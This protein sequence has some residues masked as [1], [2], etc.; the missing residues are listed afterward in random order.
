MLEV[1]ACWAEKHCSTTSGW[2]SFDTTPGTTCGTDTN[3]PPPEPGASPS[4]ALNP[5]AESVTAISPVENCSPRLLGSLSAL[6]SL[7]A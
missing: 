3:A 7:D 4:V 2:K 1:V 5:G 6:N